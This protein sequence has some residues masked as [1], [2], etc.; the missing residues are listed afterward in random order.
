MKL[1]KCNKTI[2]YITT[3][4]EYNVYTGGYSFGK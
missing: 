3:N 2:T 1:I 4:Y